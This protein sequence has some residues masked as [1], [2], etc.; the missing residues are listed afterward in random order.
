METLA[1]EEGMIDEQAL[2]QELQSSRD[3]NI[4]LHAE[5]C[6][7]QAKNEELKRQLERSTK[8]RRL[9]IVPDFPGASNVVD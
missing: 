2:H 5:N 6:V 7:L 3:E 1:N 4:V 8:S 9:T